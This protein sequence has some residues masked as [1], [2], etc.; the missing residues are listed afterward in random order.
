MEKETI[1]R[2]RERMNIERKARERAEW[3]K[4]E[5]EKGHQQ[6]SS[7]IK[8]KIMENFLKPVHDPVVQ[9]YTASKNVCVLC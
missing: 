1:E 5:R 9:V 8:T 4:V 3:G 7:T 2:E 6:Q